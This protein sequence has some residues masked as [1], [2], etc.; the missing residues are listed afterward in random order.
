[1]DSRAKVQIYASNLAYPA[2]EF[3]I[4]PS[5]GIEEEENLA[6]L[7]FCIDGE[8]GEIATEIDKFWVLGSDVPYITKSIG[9]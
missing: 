3:M 2:A 1:M 5:H 7:T 9:D 6:W 8:R 4:P